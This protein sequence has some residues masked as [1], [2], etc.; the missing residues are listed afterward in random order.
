MTSADRDPHPA[1]S[2]AR[3][4]TRSASSGHT[5]EEVHP[6]RRMASTCSDRWRPDGLGAWRH[7]WVHLL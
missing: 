7:R 3:S 6:F 1:P 2:S 4:S 5:D